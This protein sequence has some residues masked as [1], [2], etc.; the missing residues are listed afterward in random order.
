MNGRIEC[1]NRRFLK[2][3]KTGKLQSDGIKK[4]IKNK[5]LFAVDYGSI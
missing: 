1:E 5:S 4:R 3:Y 2:D